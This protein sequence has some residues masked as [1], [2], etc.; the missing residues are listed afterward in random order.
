MSAPCFPYTEAD[1]GFLAARD[2]ALGAAM[3]EIGRVE[4]RVMPDVF[5]A[6]IHSIAGQQI[7]TKAQATVWR[8][9]CEL[10]G[11]IRPERLLAAGEEG[12][13]RCGLSGRKAGYMRAA[14]EAV[15]SGALDLEALQAMSDAAVVETLVRLPGVGV[16]TAE[17][18]LLFSLCRRDVFSTRDFGIRRG[19]SLL[20]GAEHPDETLFSAL[21]ARYSPLGSVASLYL[22]EISARIK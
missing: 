12:L 6:L 3:R 7:S 13:I 21:R 10:L 17:M 8:R 11:D 5:Q 15:L 16:W 22:W 19:V 14:A 1:I 20:Y 9:L 2:P 4:R 18:L